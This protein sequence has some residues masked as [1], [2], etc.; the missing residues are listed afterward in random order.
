MFFFCCCCFS[1]QIFIY[2][3]YIF[4]Q[5]KKLVLVTRLQSCMCTIKNL[6][7]FVMQMLYLDFFSY[8]SHGSICDPDT[9][10]SY[11][12]SG[13]HSMSLAQLGI[14][15]VLM[16]NIW[17]CLITSSPTVAT[18]SLTVKHRKD[19]YLDFILT[20]LLLV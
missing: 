20:C 14:H 6:K 7:M 15:T 5:E 1:S 2:T 11:P 19:G 3:V 9:R 13:Q 16:K 17:T 12:H 8:I 4:P 18:F 10:M